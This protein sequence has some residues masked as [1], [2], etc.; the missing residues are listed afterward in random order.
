[1]HQKYLSKPKVET[2][3]WNVRNDPK[4]KMKREINNMSICIITST[5][6]KIDFGPYNVAFLTIYYNYYKT[7]NDEACV[8]N[9]TQ[10]I[11]QWLCRLVAR[12]DLVN[13]LLCR[14]VFQDKVG[15]KQPCSSHVTALVCSWL[16]L[17]RL[18]TG[19]LLIFERT[20]TRHFQIVKV[21]S[22]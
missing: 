16:W 19:W 11:S 4:F 17:R 2:K 14:R 5:G 18:T 22:D 10:S 8:N 21:S 13:L 3:G 1:M 15:G 12:I 6:I 7:S 20:F 9:M